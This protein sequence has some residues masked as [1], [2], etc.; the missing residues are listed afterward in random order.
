M[1]H[2]SGLPLRCTLCLYLGQMVQ[3]SWLHLLL[4]LLLLLFFSLLLLLLLLLLLHAGQLW[5][6]VRHKW[7]RS[8]HVLLACFR[9]HGDRCRGLRS[10]LKL[11]RWWDRKTG[12]CA[13]RKLLL[14]VGLLRLLQRLVLVLVWRHDRH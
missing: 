13:G 9:S 3:S 4:L 12:V 6:R 10:I 8:S 14:P 11:Q 1:P 5:E 7:D 2:R